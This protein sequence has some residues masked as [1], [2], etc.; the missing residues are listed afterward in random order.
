LVIFTR[1]FRA[2]PGYWP[3]EGVELKPF[4]ECTILQ[5]AAPLQD[6]ALEYRNTR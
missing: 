5:F 6:A 3:G 1:V 2:C 4:K